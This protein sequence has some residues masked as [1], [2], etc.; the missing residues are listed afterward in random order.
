M[1]HLPVVNPPTQFTV[2]G[3]L[4]SRERDTIAIT[5]SDQKIFYK[6]KQEL[7]LRKTLIYI[8]LEKEIKSIRVLSSCHFLS[9]L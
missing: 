6:Q 7:G 4:V 5:A 2:A 9:P 8:E 1:H 3:W